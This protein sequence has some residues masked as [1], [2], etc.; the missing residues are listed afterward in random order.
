MLFVIFGIGEELADDLHVIT[1][2]AYDIEVIHDILQVKFCVVFGQE[3]GKTGNMIVMVVCDEPG[4]DGHLLSL[5]DAGD[6]PQ[7]CID[8]F[9]VSVTHLNI[10][11]AVYY[12]Q[13][14][15]CELDNIHGP[16]IVTV[17]TTVVAGVQEAVLGAG[18]GDH[19]QLRAAGA[20]A[21][22]GIADAAQG[23][24]IGVYNDTG[25]LICFHIIGINGVGAVGRQTFDMAVGTGLGF[26][27]LLV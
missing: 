9:T 17:L 22:V 13:A 3:T 2:G 8:P 12:K 23:I 20:T 10:T 11:A 7:E 6:P 25:L 26:N 16:C 4:V 14:V 5:W 15:I 27:S 24:Y 21:T 18:E 19:V 1:G